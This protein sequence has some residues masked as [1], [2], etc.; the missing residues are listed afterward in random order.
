MRFGKP[1][2]R[3]RPEILNL[4]QRANLPTGAL[5]DDHRIGCS[6][7][8]EPGG[9]VRRLTND[10][11]LLRG[12]CPNQITDDHKSTGDPN[13]CLE[14]DRFD[15]EATDSVD[16]PQPRPDRPLGV[17]LMRSRV[18]EINQYTVAHVP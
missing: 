13:A 10:R 15:I 3:L 9:E 17:I 2:E 18:A 7:R 8:L 5:G 16:S 4:E 11:L 1:G 12:T 14:L 6:Q